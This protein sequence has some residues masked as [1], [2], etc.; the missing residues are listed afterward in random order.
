MATPT[1]KT[2]FKAW[3][4]RK[5]G[6]PVIDINIDNDQLDDR[7]DEALEFYGKF[8]GSGMQRVYLKHKVTQQ[9]KDRSLTNT[10]ETA[11]A[12]GTAASE[13]GTS[14][15]DGAVSAA[16]TSIQLTDATSFP[17]IGTVTIAA[18]ATP[19]AEET[20]TY[21]AKVGNIL[22]TAALANNH[23]SGT[24]VTLKV[25]ADWG[26]GQGYLPMPDNI[27]SVLRIL[28]FSDRGNLNMFDIRYQL[29]LN[30]LY[31]F[32][33]ISVIH[34]QM[35]MWQL[36]LLDMLLVGE[37]PIQFNIHQKRLYINMDWAND[38]AVNEYL[39]IECFRKLDPDQYTEVWNDFWLKRYATAL[40]KRQWGENLI[41]FQGVTLLGGVQ[42]NGETIYNEAIREI[43]E[44]EEQGRLTYEEPLMFDIG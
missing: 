38:I 34:Y 7:V 42:M 11:T 21:T 9:D 22:T 30:D 18:D 31:D 10:L 3:C 20:V 27:L 43:G 17:K 24:A 12:T 39:I 26:I 5:L 32:S 36:D 2:E 29:R 1:T 44:L 4:K 15:L 13:I 41:K 16:G 40:I 35:T 6:Y 19:N 37:K 25:T 14:F 33:S 8:M 28:P 23:I